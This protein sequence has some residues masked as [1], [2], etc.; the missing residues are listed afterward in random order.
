MPHDHTH[1]HTHDQAPAFMGDDPHFRR[2]LFLVVVIN[3][4]MFVVEMLA[5]AWAGSMALKADALDF[6]ADTFTYGL[7]FWA[8]SW[9]ARARAQAALFKGVTLLAM[10]LYVLG[11]TLYRFIDQI[12]PEPLV[13]S[14]VGI[15]ALGANILA[16]LLLLKWRM[17]DANIR[18]VWL[19]SRNDMIGNLAVVAAAAGV[20]GLGTAWPD[21]IV[22]FLMAGLFTHSAVLII[23]QARQEMKK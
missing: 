21:L 11:A 17:G 9:S 16:V 8:L 12:P 13:M 6:L 22:A 2:A 10:A 15:M 14:M 18:S 7:S 4:L 20:F 23:R 5:G 3:A 1:H 19:C